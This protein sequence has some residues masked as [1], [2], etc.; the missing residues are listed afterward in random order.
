MDK[1]SWTYSKYMN[2]GIPNFVMERKIVHICSALSNEHTAGP[3]TLF[4]YSIKICF[5]KMYN[6]QWTV[7]LANIFSF[8]SDNV[9]T[10]RSKLQNI[11]IPLKYSIG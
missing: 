6:T 2:S 3:I 7:N 1:I 10:V 5:I 8:V 9:L 4:H 11:Q